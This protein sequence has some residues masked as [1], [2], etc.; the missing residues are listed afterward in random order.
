MKLIF[1]YNYN[2]RNDADILVRVYE[3]QNEKFP[4]NE[5]CVGEVLFKK[6]L[7]IDHERFTSWLP[8]GCANAIVQILKKNEQLDVSVGISNEF[9][10]NLGVLTSVSENFDGDLQRDLREQELLYTIGK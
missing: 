9:D 2:T 7:G 4:E 6:H 10:S 1:N 5:Q 8:R 3:N